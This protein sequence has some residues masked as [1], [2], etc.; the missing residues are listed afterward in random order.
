MERTELLTELKKL[1]NMKEVKNGFPSKESCIEWGNKVAPLLK[2]NKSYHTA[3][4]KNLSKLYLD[5]SSYTLIPAF[6]S[7][8]SQIQMAINELEYDRNDSMENNLSWL[9]LTDEYGITKRQFGKKISFIKDKYTRSVIFRDI[10]HAYIL[11]KNGFSK[12][13]VILS[14]A[15]IEEMLRQ[16]LIYKNI[17]P[18]KNTFNEYIKSCE[19]NNLLKKAINKLSDSVREFRNIVHISKETT[20]KHTISKATAIGAITSIFTVANDF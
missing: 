19:D 20:K 9:T 2:F 14:G 7:M 16:Y 6:R 1:Y 15:I 11:A 10:E 3:F 13:A 5:L 8:V 4:N 18:Q 12:P 17:K